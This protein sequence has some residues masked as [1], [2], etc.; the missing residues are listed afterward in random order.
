[1]FNFLKK[2]KFSSFLIVTALFMVIA[3]IA[4]GV[5]VQSGYA[6]TNAPKA[7]R[8][9]D[10]V[11]GS[12]TGDCMSIANPCATISY[13]ISQAGAGDMI[14]VAAGTYNEALSITKNLSIYGAGMASVTID[15]SGTTG[16]GISAF[17][18]ITTSFYGFTLIGPPAATNG[19]GMKVSGEDAVVYITSVTVKNSGRSGIDLNG[20]AAGKL[21]DIVVKDNGGVG[22]ALTDTSNVTIENITTSGNNWGG[23]GIYTYGGSYTGGSDGI[24]IKGTNSYAELNPLYTEIDNVSDSSNPYPI[25]NFTQTDFFYTVHNDTDNPNM[26]GY[27]QTLERAIAAALNPLVPTPE[28]SYIWDLVNENFVVGHTAL[29]EM[30]IQA[31]V[32][33]AEDGD[34]IQVLDG[35]YVETVIVDDKDITIQ[36]EGPDTIIQAEDSIPVCTTTS[37]DWHAM[38]C[39]INDA[40]LVLQ[41]LTLDGAAKG[42]ANYKFM[43]VGF[44]NA[45]GA[46]KNTVIKDVRNEPFSGAQHGVGINLYND[47]AT[48]RTVDVLNN[49]IERFQKNAMA[50]NAAG[51]TPL[52]I[53]V[54]SNTITGYGTIT[55]TAQNGVQAWAALGSGDVISN[56]ISGI[57]YDGDYWVASSILLI[58]GDSYNVMNNTVTGAQVGVYAID[59][60]A[61]IEHNEFEIVESGD[62][63]F[64]VVPTDPPDAHPALFGD[65]ELTNTSSSGKAPAG[66]D[67]TIEINYN[68]VTY[69]DAD[70]ADT[71]G[72]DAVAG[73]GEDNIEITAQYNKVTGFEY[74]V[75]LYQD[76]EYPGVFNDAT[77]NYNCLLDNDYGLWSNIDTFTVDATKNFWGDANGPDTTAMT[78]GTPNPNDPNAL[79]GIVEG[80][81]EIIPWYATCTTLP[82]TEYVTVYDDET[83]ANVLAYSDTVQGGVDAPPDGGYVVA[84]AR[85]FEESVV[86]S[87]SDIL[88][89]GTGTGTVIKAEEDIPTCVHTYY[90]WHPIVCVKDGLDVAIHDLTIDG[91]GRGNG[92]Y[93]F[94]GIAYYNADG[95]VENVVIKDV[96]DTPFSGAQHGVALYE[97]SDDGNPHAFTAMNNT[98]TGFQKNGITLN[99]AGDTPLDVYVKD[100]VITGA[101]ATD[102]TAQNGIE[103]WADLAEGD[104]VGNTIS[105]IGYD[106]TNASTKW[107]GTSILNIFADL[108][109]YDN[110]IT[111]AQMGMYNWD[112][113]VWIDS[114]DITVEKIGFSSVGINA[115]DPPDAV[116]SPLGESESI[117]AQGEVRASGADDTG[118]TLNVEISNNKVQFVGADYTNTY[119]IRSNAGYGDSN[120]DLNVHHNQVNGFDYGI[121]LHSCEADW[122][123][124]E[125]DG[126]FVGLDVN[127]NCLANNGYGIYSDFTR[128]I[129]NGLYNWWGDM[130]GPFHPLL[131]AGGLGSQVSNYVDFD[132]WEKFGCGGFHIYIPF[133]VVTR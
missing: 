90:D 106:N 34:I 77:L 124:C 19:Y 28:A 73:W 110:T 64:G 20:V 49:D 18:D 120:I 113:N 125:Y 112:G 79:G 31:A 55:T 53:D 85:T 50:L 21:T 48:D 5:F 65:G 8:Y 56:T 10:G 118:L 95:D 13:A 119:G 87:R 88:L 108:D 78:G 41:D 103:I 26:V 46:V 93:R 16:Y 44:R 25:T 32:D 126:E 23:V 123:G 27:Q 111:G 60:N 82:T 7:I 89:E 37:Y 83:M 101:G 51:D 130:T 38:V 62:Y 3:L 61:N 40:N 84:S 4:A 127:Y 36:G 72:I 109:I 35:T 17:G 67:L 63:S 1:M 9:V 2:S 122:M 12:D 68:T 22:L 15:A 81:V 75:S 54:E 29:K 104:I 43:G 70:N 96:R 57:A 66:R 71:V 80:D 74:G 117:P 116:P 99:A 6:E 129:T 69:V 133:T 98:V 42:N 91:A 30:S 86:I 39:I 33:A 132:P 128:L 131:N 59:T 47:D 52:E 107:V 76:D 94:M 97:Y 105:G 115:E 92:N 24:T 58:Y 14:Q 121:Y 102:V 114:N 45:G 100:N 11:T